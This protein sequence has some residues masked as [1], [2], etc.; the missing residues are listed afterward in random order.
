METVAGKRSQGRKIERGTRGKKQRARGRGQTPTPPPLVL[1]LNAPGMTPLLRAG[2][3]GLASA[4]RFQLLEADQTAAWPSEV[5]VGGGRAVIEPQRITLL[6]NDAAP[7]D[8]LQALFTSTFR[9]SRAGIITLAGTFEPGSPPS[10]PLAIAL[11]DGLKRTFLQHGKFTK[12]AGAL[13]S[14]SEEV[15][16]QRFT[17]EWQPYASYAHQ[18]AWPEIEKA[19]SHNISIKFAGWAYPGAA[20]KHKYREAQCEYA[21][22]HGLAACFSVV[23]CLSFGV[24][25]GGMGALVILEPSDLIKFA[26]TRPRLTPARQAEAF[27]ASLGDAVLQTQLALRMDEIARQHREIAAM[28]GVLLKTLPWASQQK[29][30]CRAIDVDATPAAML[31]VFERIS[32]VL[33]ARLIAKSANDDDEIEG[34]Y[35]VATSALHAFVT[36]NLATGK[37]WYAGFA[38]ATTGGKRPRFLHYYRDRDNLGALYAEERKGLIIM[39]ENLDDAEKALVK[40]VHIALRNRFGRIRKETE[41]LPVATR[42]KR[43][44]RERERWRLAFAGAKTLD[45]VRA[46]LANLWSL[47]APNQELRRSW[48]QILPLLCPKHWQVARDLSL[49]ALASYRG[50]P[51]DE[52]KVTE[53]PSAE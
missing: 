48:E 4:L 21:A 49:V 17:Y 9:I 38:T 52:D 24:R 26:I 14:A 7:A 10:R 11:Q 47:A 35:F 22:A 18:K 33:P 23:G 25:P 36:D 13:K 6:W 20:Q 44:D 37:R 30:R 19:R 41:K 51:K 32:R 31:D 50:S 5:E 29:N 15:D 39:T 42:K 45:Q 8:V 16:D 2:L 40:S 28:H 34:G 53:E 12:K 46:A 43:F 3:G 27:V 1:E